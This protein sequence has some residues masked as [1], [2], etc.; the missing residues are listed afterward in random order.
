VKHTRNTNEPGSLRS[1]ARAVYRRILCLFFVLL[2]AHLPLRL[3]A[4]EGNAF[5]EGNRLYEEGRYADAVVVYGKLAEAK[6]GSAALFFNL[7]NAFFKSGRIGQAIAAY[8][9]AQAIS[10]RDPDV[11]ANLEFARKQ[12]KGP[13][14]PLSRVQQWLGR[15]TLNEWTLLAVTALWLWILTL[16][17]MQWRPGLRPVLK[18]YAFGLFAG[19]VFCGACL[20][21][22]LHESLAVRVAIVTSGDA[23][24]RQGPFEE[25]NIA[26]TLQDGAELRVLDEKEQWLQVSN[27]QRSI[28]W[29]R[30]NQALIASGTSRS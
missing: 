5:D 15:L 20:G 8:R 21:V 4:R 10:P 3:A 14:L 12:V 18:F 30:Q 7:G 11:R 2:L 26:F 29:L 23:V 6:P 28:G 17:A 24:A 27:G 16:A 9:R 19:V 22:A 25:S 13:T 1:G